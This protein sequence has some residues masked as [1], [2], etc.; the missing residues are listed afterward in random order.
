VADKAESCAC[1]RHRARARRFRTRPGEPALAYLTLRYDFWVVAA[2]ILIA[3]FASWVALDLAKRA[4]TRRTTAQRTGSVQRADEPLH[5]A[6]QELQRRAHV[7]A[8]TGLPNRLLFEDRLSHAMARTNRREGDAA[9]AHVDRLAVLFIDIDG[10]RCVNDSFGH[11]AG[12]AVLVEAAQRLRESARASDTVARVGGDAY[13]LLM[14]E[15]FDMADCV[16]L[17]TRLIATLQRPFDVP[18]GSVELSASVGIAVYPDH[19]HRDELIAHAD[20]AMHA[21]KRDGGASHALFDS[22]KDAS[23]PARPN[24]QTTG[25]L[26]VYAAG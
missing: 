26:P 14:E 11:D 22:N 25:A 17:A 23:A 3:G 1:I 4:R 10:F 21:A 2:S 15:V 6:N 5:A 7:D 13:L 19:G 16:V 9:V 8:L 18:G 20:A 24:L 12:D